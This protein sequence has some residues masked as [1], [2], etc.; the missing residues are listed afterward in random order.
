MKVKGQQP[1]DT[2]FILDFSTSMTWG[3]NKDH[4]S[5]DKKDSRIQAL[6][7]SVNDA[8]DTLVKANPE[9]RIAIAVFNGSSTALLPELTTGSKILE[10]VPDGNY[11]EITGY[12]FEQGKDGGTA[13]VTCKINDEK[14]RDRQRHQ[15]PG[16]YVCGNEDPGGQ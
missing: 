3:Y 14:S 16:G 2:V 15:Y 10:K 7:D 4:E 11:L 9:N 13:E 1:T 12:H 5:V 6:V 8:I